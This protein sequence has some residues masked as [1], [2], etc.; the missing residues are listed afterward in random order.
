MRAAARNNV[1]L[2]WRVWQNTGF[3]HCD[4]Q[5]C[6]RSSVIATRATSESYSPGPSSSSLRTIEKKCLV[7]KK[8]SKTLYEADNHYKME[9]WFWNCTVPGNSLNQKH[10]QH[11]WLLS[12]RRSRGHW[13]R[14]D[15]VEL[16]LSHEAVYWVWIVILTQ[17]PFVNVFQ[18]D[19]SL[20]S[21]VFLK[22]T[23]FLKARSE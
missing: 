15:C 18:H 10:L 17:G 11:I 23:T 6:V 1:A 20:Y 16:C 12:T 3:R 5:L 2:D 9:V 19:C 14:A 22:S 21:A 8:P 7:D 13:E 4:V